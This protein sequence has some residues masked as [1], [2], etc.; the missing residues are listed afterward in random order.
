[1]KVRYITNIEHYGAGKYSG[2]GVMCGAGHVYGEAIRLKH[3]TALLPQCTYNTGAGVPNPPMNTFV[4]QL[5][6]LTISAELDAEFSDVCACCC[7]FNVKVEF[8]V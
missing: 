3:T 4:E 5:H 1:M 7:L 6:T 2:L 8:C